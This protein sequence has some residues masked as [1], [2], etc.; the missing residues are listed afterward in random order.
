MDFKKMNRKGEL[1]MT[2]LIIS[3]IAIMFIFITMFQFFTSKVEGAGV[4]IP[5]KY[6]DTYTKILNS[7]ED[8]DNDLNSISNAAKNITEA[9]DV[10]SVALN[11]FKG[12]GY[13]LLLSLEFVS[14][15]FDVISA[16]L[17]P[18]DFVP[19][20][21]KTLIIMAITAVVLFLIIANAKGEPKT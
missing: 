10:F 18:L 19:Q 20:Y 15:P 16:I 1:T 5:V 12:L 11:G 6:N 21:Q 9:D 8:L 13:V 7:Q 3:I 17:I 4:T 2:T 14:T